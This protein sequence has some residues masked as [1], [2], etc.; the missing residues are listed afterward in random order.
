MKKILLS[1]IFLAIAG[2]ASAQFSKGSYYLGGSL[3][4]NYDEAGTSTTY[5]YAGQGVDVYTQ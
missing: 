5:T 3:N 4:Y 1:L 2:S